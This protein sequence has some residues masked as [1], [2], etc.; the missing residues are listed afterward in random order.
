MAITRKSSMKTGEK[1]MFT[2]IGVVIVLA[3]VGFVAMEVV[4]HRSD[5]PMFANNTHYNFSKEGLEGHG[6]YNDSQCSTCHRAMRSGTSMGLILDGIGSKRS[7]EWIER[8]LTS[9]ETTYGAVTVD[10]GLNKAAGYVAELPPE[11][12]RKMSI[13][14]SE[15][16]ADPGSSIA[17]QPPPERSAV[18]DE[19]VSTFAPK[20]WKE[21]YKD[22]DQRLKKEPSPEVMPHEGAPPE[23]AEV[24]ADQ[25]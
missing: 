12:I 4:R 1:V 8:F 3:M 20:E 14:L 25:P 18:V 2:V 19:M 9:P 22:Q 6:I 7:P 15:M 5:T 17:R 11:K 23:G 24:Q 16:R 21:K 13:F 10:H